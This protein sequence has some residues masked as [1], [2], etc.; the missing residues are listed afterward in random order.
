VPFSGFSIL[1]NDNLIY[2]TQYDYNQSFTPRRKTDMSVVKAHY[3]LD[4][5]T[6]RTLAMLDKSTSRIVEASPYRILVYNVN[7]VTGDVTN[8]V[9]KSTN[10]F[11]VFYREMPVAK[12]GQ[13]LI[14][15]YDGSIYDQGLNLIATI[16][17]VNNGYSDV[18]FS[19]DGQF[20][21][22]TYQDFTVG[23]GTLIQ[24][25]TFPGMEVV[26]SRR[27][28]NASP[29]SV[30]AVEGGVIFVGGSINGLNQVLVKRLDF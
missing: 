18:D 22:A 1:V 14:A 15:Q 30:D 25:F 27:F 7:P 19:P 6:H 16:P 3:R 28:N 4:Y 23:N 9:E 17:F 8:M 2:T 24:K 10:T 11:N 21:Y 29:R 26:A 13:Y 12:N 5:Y 20:I